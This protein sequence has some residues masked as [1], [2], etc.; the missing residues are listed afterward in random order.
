MTTANDDTTTLNGVTVGG[1]DVM[2][3]SNV[4]V[5]GVVDTNLKRE[6]V[7]VGGELARE[8]IAEVAQESP[9]PSAWGLPVRELTVPQ[10]L[11]EL[12]ACRMELTRIRELLEIA[13]SNEG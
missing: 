10:V 2:D 4:T 8:A 6:R 3:V 12:Q 9:L 7:V 11:S 5:D 13:F 1:G